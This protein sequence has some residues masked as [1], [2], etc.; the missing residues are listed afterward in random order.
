MLR[1]F[2]ERLEDPIELRRNL[3][4]LGINKQK[5]QKPVNQPGLCALNGGSESLQW[6]YIATVNDFPAV[7]ACLFSPD[8]TLSQVGASND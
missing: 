7:L 8:D 1:E 6:L 4:K 2:V 5:K 3:R